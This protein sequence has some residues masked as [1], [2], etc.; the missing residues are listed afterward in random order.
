MV[1]NSAAAF[2]NFSPKAKLTL[3]TTIGRSSEKYHDLLT[4]DRLAVYRRR[5][6][7]QIIDLRDIDILRCFVITEFNNCF[8]S[9]LSSLF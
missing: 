9:D 2:N 3:K 6:L 4:E 7:R 5:R 8:T 1:E